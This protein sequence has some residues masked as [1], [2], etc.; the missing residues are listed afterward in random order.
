[1]AHARHPHRYPLSL[2]V[3]LTAQNAVEGYHAIVECDYL[4][5]ERAKFKEKLRE[6]DIPRVSEGI[7]ALL[8]AGSG[9]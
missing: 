4:S 6:P 1:M 9:S 3:S 2:I 8:S 5:P 7:Q